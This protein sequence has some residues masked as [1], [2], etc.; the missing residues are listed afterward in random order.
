MGCPL[1]C[2]WC[3]TPESQQSEGL[4]FNPD[5]CILCGA[6]IDVCPTGAISITN[7]NRVSIDREQCTLCF[8]CTEECYSKSLWKYG[9]LYSGEEL[10]TEAL[11]DK[12]F[13]KNSGGGITL[14]GGECLLHV[15]DELVQFCA[16]LNEEGVSVGIDTCGHVP[17]KNIERVLPFTEFF[18]WD[19]KVLN[20]VLHKQV[21][22]VDNS[23]IIENLRN[24][25]SITSSAAKDLY[26]RYPLVPT[27]NDSKKDIE[28]LCIFLKELKDFKELHLLPF[29]H[30]GANRYIYSGKEYLLQG[31]ALQSREKLAQTLEI[32]KS[33]GIPCRIVG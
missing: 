17:F 15:D 1:S 4:G 20:P 7:E 22:G 12:P 32:P 23:L 28:Q 21:T 33:Y 2:R 3:S 26:I 5:R 24:V 27:I 18:L 11:K 8:K 30:L 14:S 9:N 25:A 16:R 31:L 10:F 13:F 29:H 6:C 19:I